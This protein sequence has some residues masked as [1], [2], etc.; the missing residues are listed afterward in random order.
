MPAPS[1]WI[2]VAESNFDHEREALEFVRSQFPSHEPY[3]AW[4]NFEFI[5]SDGSINEVDLLVFTPQGFF[6]IEIKSW[7]GKLSGDAGTWI[8][9]RLDGRRRTYDNPIKLTNLKA[10]RLKS[11]LGRQR[12]FKGRKGLPF[13]EPLVFLS[14]DR[15]TL[16][17]PVE[18]RHGVCLKDR[19]REGKK[20][21]RTG[22]MSAIMRR[23]CQGLRPLR[24]TYSRPIAKLIG[25]AMEQA[26]IRPSQ[27]LRQVSDYVLEKIIDSG[28]G[29][30]DWSATHT[31]IEKTKR[32]IR[33]YLVRRE[34]S[35]DDKAMIE[36]AAKR[37]FQ[38]LESLQHPGILRAYGLSEHELGPALVLEHDPTAIRLDHYLAQRQEPLGI[39]V[40]LDLMRQIAEAMR[41][42]HEQRVIHRGINPRSILVR[43]S[44]AGYPKT[45]IINWQLGYRAGSASMGASHEVTA[46]DH[47]DR[48]VEDVNTAYLAPEA[49]NDADFIG[50]HLDIFSLGAIAFYLFS[51]LPPAANGLELSQKLRETNGLQISSVLNGA[52]ESLQ[53]LILD[54][55][56]PNVDYR[57][58]TVADFLAKLDEVEEALTEPENSLVN[59]PNDA[60]QGDVL[61]G[62]FKVL[63]RLGQGACSVGFLVTKDG[64]ENVLK[65]ANDPEHNG[66]IQDEAEVLA[67]LRHSHI[68]DFE[69]RV[70]VGN[71]LGIL[72]QPVLVER[73]KYRIETLGQ[74]L[75]KEGP[76][77]ID[78]LQRFGEDL[79]DVVKFLDEQGISHRDI[80]P[81][82]IAIGQVGRGDKLHLV[83]FDFSLSRAPRDNIKAGTPGYLDPLLILRQPPQWDSYGERYAAAVTLYEMTTGTLP[84]WGDGVTDPSFVEGEITLEPERFEATLRE[85]LT[86]FF[87]TAFRR[88]IEERFDN[89]EEMLRAWRQCF[90]G[91]EEP[92]ALLE[93]EDESALKTLLAGATFDTPIL[94]LA[95]GTRSTNALDLANILTVKDLLKTP[96]RKLQRLR[97]VGHKTRREILAVTRVLRAELG[98]PTLSDLGS[99]TAEADLAAQ[100]A[101]GSLSV[102]RL[103]QQIAKPSSKDGA[104]A[105]RTLEA[106]LGLNDTFDDWPSQ[107]D[108]GRSRGRIGQLTSKFQKRWSKMPAVT[109]L[110]NDVLDILKQAGR[111]MTAG[112]VALALLI[113]RGSLT[114]DPQLRTRQ[115]MAL[116]RAAVEVERCMVNPRFVVQRGGKSIV[117]AVDVDWA[118]YGS[119]LGEEA[120]RLAQED[121]LVSPD[122]AIQALQ[123]IAPPAEATPLPERRLLQLAAAASQGA[124][125]SSRQELYPRDM[126]AERALR[127]SQ[128]ALYGVPSLTVQQVK[129]RVS[130]RYPEAAKLPERPDLD[131]LL[132][133]F[134]PALTWD[135][136][137]GCY[138]N[139]AREHLS[140]SS[141]TSFAR[142][143][144][145]AFSED[146]QEMTPEEADARLLEDRLKRGIK[147]GSFLALLVNPKCY[148]RAQQE[149]CDRFP[150]QL[151][152]YEAL[153][154]DALKRVAD[155]AKVK[156]DLVLQADANP[157]EGDWDKLM[158]LVRRAMPLVEAE[159]LK[160][161]Q[162]IVLIYPG[163]LARYDQMTLLERLRE[164]VGREDGIPGVWLLLP[165]QQQATI[166]GKAVPLLSPGQRAKITDEWLENRHRAKI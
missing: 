113:A 101:S 46:T 22:I 41:F 49:L 40:Q 94:E 1:N 2:T 136:R 42:A 142:L 36:R 99:D 92:G 51:G 75:R 52:P 98:T 129:A 74:R 20:P 109:Q 126:E 95:L 56:H 14:S 134:I 24:D 82:N 28:P 71:R 112:E 68:V 48:L 77:R 154:L 157:N 4:S 57:T 83:L 78:L 130:G 26:G 88:K 116:L 69:H 89:A 122:R 153:F 35:A 30:Q 131:G 107:T 59:N 23:E 73:D 8:L 45:Q 139:R 132:Q 91:I 121:P 90:E 123:E 70:E 100:E 163:L 66:R 64:K 38:L 18:S 125:L 12:A 161:T 149:L 60:R 54:S 104:S 152:D 34:A 106:L 17:L 133:Q 15:L 55:T 93:T 145:G 65:V 165:N 31:Q 146:G 44:R 119:K 140:L 62:H 85:R 97:G 159:L 144:T 32:R 160:A 110:R 72:M 58:E 147:E 156:W 162:T 124:A 86:A 118:T 150:V 127:L 13:I 67:Q 164:K 115:A 137:A 19:P 143:P 16:S 103:V 25:Q 128:G 102:D 9:E 50:E 7:P 21:A 11:L 29:Y 96:P 43:E 61:A 39:D 111:V 76:L 53:H 63:K 155:R 141:S 151:V 79:L 5:A 120:D 87:E 47:V 33:F 27:K 148:Q 158:L 166:D 37:E 81:D 10:K 3:R 105:Q 138:V 108:M 84:V 135:A 117:V 114:D 80:K 6:L